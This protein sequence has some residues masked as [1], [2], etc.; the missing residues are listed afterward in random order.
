MTQEQFNKS[1]RSLLSPSER[2]IISKL[3]TPFLIQDYL[4]HFPENF[5]KVGE[6]IQNPREV[7][8][9]QKAHCI[10]GAILAA[11]SLA[12]HGREPLLMDFQTRDDDEDHVIALFKERGLWGAISKTNHP[13][14]RWRDPVFKTPRELA[15]SYFNEYFMWHK[16]DGKKLGDKTM[17][18]WSAPFNLRRYHP[19][20]IWGEG[21][22]D[23]LA[24]ELDQSKHFPA[25][26]KGHQKF[27]RKARPVEIKAMSAV[28]WERKQKPRSSHLSPF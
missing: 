14:L 25:Y 1:L 26:P 21:D 12:Y 23:W 15:M 18:A 7:L 24:E 10:E 16:S 4:D 6:A 22:L 2:R 19:T 5:S 27:L 20:R 11:S 17:R 3:K 28:E 8:T 9:H 13:V